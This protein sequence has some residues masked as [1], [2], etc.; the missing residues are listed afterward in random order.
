MSAEEKSLLLE[1]LCG[2][3]EK[4]VGDAKLEELSL[5]DIVNL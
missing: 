4:Y 3:L 2:S 1:H 5:E